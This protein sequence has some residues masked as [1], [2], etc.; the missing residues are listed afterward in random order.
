MFKVF[1]NED[2]ALLDPELKKIALSTF[3]FALLLFVT[4]FF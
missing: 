4:S 1:K 3:V 2:P